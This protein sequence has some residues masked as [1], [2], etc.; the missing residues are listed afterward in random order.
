MGNSSDE[1]SALNTDF[2]DSEEDVAE[3]FP[4]SIDDDN[5]EGREHSTED[6]NSPDSES[7]D[8]V[9]SYYK[10]EAYLACYE[11]IIF[12]TNGPNLWI[13]TQYPDV[14]PPPYRKPIG[15]PPKARKKDPNEE[16]KQKTKMSRRDFVGKCSKCGNPGHNKR[17]CKVSNNMESH[18]NP[19]RSA[20][21]NEVKSINSN[22]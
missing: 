21:P 11:P 22:L 4:A 8:Y 12:P 6:H 9:P 18:G 13:T 1:D 3:Y 15:R 20:Q 5:L 2:D 17:S 7:L 14:L 16:K 10:K 19:Q